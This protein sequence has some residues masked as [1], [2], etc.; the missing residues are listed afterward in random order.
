M[1]RVGAVRAVSSAKSTI[2]AAP[3]GHTARPAPTRTQLCV[4]GLAEKDTEGQ[5]GQRRAGEGP[6]VAGGGRG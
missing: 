5:P 3:T 2:A 4:L 6:A 1:H